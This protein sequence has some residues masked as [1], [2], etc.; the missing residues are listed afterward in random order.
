MNK[1]R[2]PEQTWQNRIVSH[3]EQPANQ[4]LAHELNARRHPGKQREALRG[5]LNAVGWVAPVIVSAQTGKILDGHARVEEALSQ[6]EN[7]HVPFIE[8]DVSESEELLIL[9]TF[10][11]ITNQATYDKEALDNLLHSISTGEAGLQALLTELAEREGLYLDSLKPGEMLDAEPQ[12]DRAAELNKK[13]QVKPGDL[14]QIG[15]HRLLCGDSTKAEDVARVMGGEKAVLC[16]TDPPYGQDQE[17]VPNDSPEAHAPLLAGV[18]A[19]LPLNEGIA[20]AF[21]SPRTFINWYKPMEANGFHFERM[22]WL[23]KA[24][25]CTFPWRGWI[26]KSESILVFSKGQGQWQDV[27]P[28]SHDCYYLSE[29]SGELS[30]EMGWHGSVKPLKVVTDL[31]SRT[32]EVNAITYEP[33]AGSGT[34]LVAAQNLKRKCYAVEISPDYCTVIL[35]RMQEAFPSLSL[36]R[37]NG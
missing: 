13:W 5:S 1:K 35:E 26:L 4:F 7:S 19:L 20:L 33:F 34:T 28:Y 36:E 6:D 14:W 21:Q 32:S 11:P 17:G 9:G 30:P 24:A 12:I 22:L 3:G 8:V 2:L 10:D 16:L 37:L 27:H 15:D 25:Q 23:Y 18:A 29:V 31:M